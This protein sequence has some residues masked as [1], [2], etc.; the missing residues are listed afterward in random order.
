MKRCLIWVW[1]S[2][3][4]WWGL[5]LLW[6]G[7]IY[8]VSA[9]P[10][11]TGAS[12]LATIT[13]TAPAVGIQSP[14]LLDLLNVGLRKSGHMVGFATLGLLA[15]RALSTWPSPRR[16]VL[17]AWIFTV[18]YAASDEFHQTLVPGR[19]GLLRDVVLDAAAATLALLLIPRLLARPKPRSA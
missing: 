19:A 3:V 15:W 14:G 17:A 8:Y 4:V 6:C 10:Q 1:R 9:E 5:T 11:F 13:A 2:P 16:A 18:L 7:L 12:T